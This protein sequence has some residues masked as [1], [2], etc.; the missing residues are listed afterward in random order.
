MRCPKCDEYTWSSAN[1]YGQHVCPP[2]WQVS[3]YEDFGYFRTIYASLEEEAVEK[4][5]A[6]QDVESADYYIIGSGGCE[7]IYVRLNEDSPVKRYSVEAY[8]EPTYHAK[9]I[10]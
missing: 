1:I 4:Y 2:K 7:C 8:S 3:E 6:L 10:E 9:E 5:C